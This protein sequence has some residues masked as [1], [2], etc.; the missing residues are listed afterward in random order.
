M[1]LFKKYFVYR[2]FCGNI[3]TTIVRGIKLLYRKDDYYGLQI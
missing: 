2:L 3:L 1:E